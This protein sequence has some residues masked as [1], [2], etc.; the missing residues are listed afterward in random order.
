[1]SQ[2]RLGFALVFKAVL[3]C[4]C[5][6]NIKSANAQKYVFERDFSTSVNDGNGLVVLRNGSLVIGGYGRIVVCDANGNLIRGTQFSTSGDK[7]TWQMRAM[8]DGSILWMSSTHLL[9]FDENLNLKASLIGAEQ[10]YKCGRVL[11]CDIDE[12]GEIKVLV[13]NFVLGKY[14]VTFSSSGQ[15]LFE[16]KCIE[17]PRNISIDPTSLI[18][19][20]G[21]RRFLFGGVVH[22]VLDN[23]WN[24]L[25]EAIDSKPWLGPFTRDFS[26]FSTGIRTIDHHVVVLDKNRSVNPSPGLYVID[27]S[28]SVI[29]HWDIITQPASVFEQFGRLFVLVNNSGIMQVKVYRETTPPNIAIQSDI[30][31]GHS[32]SNIPVVVSMFSSDNIETQSISY[33]VDT[34]AVSTIIGSSYS[35]S[36]DS[37][38]SHTVSASALDISGNSSEA[39]SISF[40]IDYQAPA[41]STS[42]SSGK[43]SLT[44]S[45]SLSGVKAIYTLVEGGVPTVYTQPIS[46]PANGKK[47][48]YWAEDNASNVEVAKTYP[49]ADGSLA[50]SSFTTSPQSTLGGRTI[51]STISLSSAQSTATTINLASDNPN[52]IVPASITIDAGQTTKMFSIETKP[53]GGYTQTNITATLGT[54]TRLA[55]L[56]LV[57]PTAKIRISPPVVS[58]EST[59]KATVTLSGNAP[60]GGLVVDLE[61]DETAASVPSSITVLEGLKTATFNITTGKVTEETYAYISAIVDGV[62]SEASLT[63]RPK[64]IKPTTLSITES[65]VGGTSGTGTITLSD[66]A[67]EGGLDVDLATNNA[68]VSLPLVVKVAEGSKTAN[69]SFTTSAV[70][71]TITATVS[72]KANGATVTDTI[73]VKVKPLGTLVASPSTLPGKA[74]GSATLTLSSPT[75]TPLTVSVSSS[76]PA[77][78]LASK[79]ITIAKGQT[80]GI[81]KF[82]TALVGTDT[83]STIVCSSNGLEAKTDITVQAARPSS[84][85]L[86]PSVVLGGKSSL[87]TVTIDSPAPTSGLTVALRSSDSSAVVPSFVLVPSGKTSATFTI[88][89]SK[90]TASKNITITAS[91]NGTEKTASLGVRILTIASIVFNPSSIEG[92]GKANGLLTLTDVA[93]V[94]GLTVALASDKAGVTLPSTLLVPA[95]KST[96]AFVANTLVTGSTYDAKITGTANLET[97]SGMLKVLAPAVSSFTLSS[98]SVKGGD[99]PLGTVKIA[100]ASTVDV[101]VNL[102]S[103]NAAIASLPATVTI[104][105]GQLLATFQVTTTKPSVASSVTLSATTGGLAKVVVLK[106]SP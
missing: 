35:L 29:Q 45:D 15:F 18:L 72:A 102:S 25:W 38:G 83:T 78:V 56:D 74:I 16:E 31:P 65:L 77:V 48:I 98:V 53:V 81:I 20:S 43:L 50:I 22:K 52:V 105:K 61:S 6:S 30:R 97:G 85:V 36:E 47:V 79:T 103:S 59:A 5:L 57:P 106:V 91:A 28:L 66:P 76:N 58:S 24:I 2:L 17:Q 4:L 73:E 100:K 92:G 3:L 26:S 71:S 7:A 84:V 54:Q 75:A 82:T 89:T 12:S 27:P 23:R 93:P 62:S 94:G 21:D 51:S 10:N 34:N 90:V 46:L 64:S 11:D 63:I 49:P 86:L 60:F 67:P 55:Q 14:L 88:T 1:M 32:W 101:V 41:T 69:F 96:V 70:S 68:A 9:I 42:I 99:K 8:R 13:D 40:G 87:G 39:A 44:A 104:P 33:K 19:L 95:G 37:E 80:Q